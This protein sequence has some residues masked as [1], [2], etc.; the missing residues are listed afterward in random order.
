M[1]CP[2]CGEEIVP[3]YVI[4][5]IHEQECQASIQ[6]GGGHL[7]PVTDPEVPA[8]C[9]EPG[10]TEGSHC[11]HCGEILIAQV[12]IPAKGHREETLSA[13]A[14]TCTETGLTEGLR[15]SVC[16][17][18]IVEQTVVSAL[19]HA[20]GEPV[21]TWADDYSTAMAKCVCVNDTSHTE[22]ETV[23]TTSEIVEEPT[24][25][26]TGRM[27]YTAE[28]KKEMFSTQTK[29]VEIPCLDP[30]SPPIL[31]PASTPT[32]T[33]TFSPM[34]TTALTPMPM[35]TPTST[36]TPVPSP[37][38]AP[39]STSTPSSASTPTP[40]PTTTP[41]PT[42]TESPPPTLTPTPALTSSPT[43]TTTPIPTSTPT[44]IPTHTP[45]PTPG[46][47]P[48][49]TP[50]PVPTI[51]DTFLI[52]G[53]QYKIIS[54]TAVSFTGLKKAKSKS[55]VR[56]PATIQYAGK[57]YKV[58]EVAAKALYKDTKVKT[59]TIGKNVKTIGKSAF[60]SCT[61]LKAV[62]GG[63]GVTT[64]QD[65][66]FN[67]CRV[68]KTFPILKKL[69]KIGASAFRSCVKLADFTMWTTVKSI[70]KSAFQGCS[71]LKSISVRT[72]KLNDGNVGDK[73]FKGIHPKATFSC[74]KKKLK[75]YQELFI[76]KGAPKTCQ[77]IRI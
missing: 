52:S 45:A 30:T 21:Y 74:P 59:L 42:L 37:T 6:A 26:S 40:V 10:L 12:V 58:S 17:T 53:L 31:T 34:P 35:T 3:G 69:Q 4:P 2:L 68:L 55:A 41:F 50:A 48:T 60:A 66:A 47:T 11:S 25:T 27:V 28:F 39:T 54:R 29:E 36:P 22:T 7:S 67:G 70:G 18:I 77:F 20:W 24:Y 57:T 49:S 16:G 43:S 19:G 32:P 5:S 63:T 14:A 76:R 75:A 38:E 61:K 62:K 64:I 65:A 56:I 13:V 72:S 33:P 44:A 46:P 23:E 9:T 15:C 51:G 1:V 73:A 8:T 71:S